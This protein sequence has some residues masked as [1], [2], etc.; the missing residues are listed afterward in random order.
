MIDEGKL[1][2][3]RDRAA[4][5]E[6][7]LRN[8]LLAEAF[9]ML[10][11]EY[12]KAWRATHINDTNAR[13]RLHQAVQIVAKVKDHLNRVVADGRLAQRQLDDLAAKQKRFGVL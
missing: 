10:D 2:H 3:D 13:E 11:H 12:I 5:A 7:L 6:G 1:H 4:K 9:A 8:E